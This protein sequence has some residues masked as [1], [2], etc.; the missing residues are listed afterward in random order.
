M[1]DSV[2]PPRA[3]SRTRTAALRSDLAL[4]NLRFRSKMALAVALPVCA[5]LAVTLVGVTSRAGVVTTETRVGHL[6]GP[7]SALADVTS[8]LDD[9]A[10]LS[11]WTLAS[12]AAPA[13][14]LA[15]ARLATDRAIA[16]VRRELPQLRAAH[17]DAAVTRAG[18]LFD[19]FDLLGEQRRFI[20]LG[21]MPID[22]ATGYYDDTVTIV[23]GLLDSMNGTVHDATEVANLRDFTTVVRFLAAAGQ[24]HSVLT[25]GFAQ[26]ALSTGQTNDL[27]GAIASQDAYQALFLSQAGPS[28]RAAFERGYQPDGS[29]VNR[30]HA[31]R[32]VALAG[33]IGKGTVAV[34]DWYNATTALQTSLR[35]SAHNVLQAVERSGRD[36]KRAAERAMLFYGLGAGAALLAAIGLAY[37]I[38]RSTTRPLRQLTAAARD[39]SERQLP[40]L[41]QALHADPDDADFG[42]MHPI[43]TT[44]RD[45]VGE[46][47][48]AFNAIE[49]ATVDVAREHAVL[50]RQGI[51]DLYVNLARRN[52]S[53][54]ER[55]LRAIDELESRE[56][57]P[58]TLADLFRVDH[59]AT[60]MRRNAE[61]LLIL[62]G[63]EPP[64]PSATSVR[65]F[66]VVRAAA[67]EIDD[68]A[69]IDL[70]E[71][72]ETT[73]IAG[74][75]MIDLTHLLAELLEN[76]TAFSPPDS[77]VV[78]RAVAVESGYEIAV[79]DRGL[80][81][82]SDALA[83]ANQ[84][85][86]EPAPPRL[87]LSRSLGHLVVARLAARAGVHVELRDGAPGVVA[88]VSIPAALLV[89]PE[90]A[91]GT[92]G[93][94]A[95][96]LPRRV[97]RGV[98][99][100]ARI[101]A[102][103]S[104]NGDGSPS[105][106]EAGDAEVRSAPTGWT[107][108]GLPRRIRKSAVKAFRRRTASQ[109][110]S[111][112]EVFEIVARYESGRRRGLRD[113]ASGAA[114][115]GDP[116]PPREPASDD[117]SGGARPGEQ[118]RDRVQPDALPH[119]RPGQTIVPERTEPAPRPDARSPEETFELV[120]R[121]E[122]GRRRAR[123]NG[124]TEGADNG[125]G[126]REPE[127]PGHVTRAEDG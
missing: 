32:S 112:D 21:V 64:R 53:L 45:E 44:S 69:R 99:A 59:F 71:V 73:A 93:S 88:V 19:Q 120:A 77:R 123:I 75:V 13:D 35:A 33:T 26:R 72:D 42:T 57:D 39:V 70:T 106:D 103:E 76:A 82:Q 111:P 91:T 25:A 54:I 3:R 117:A 61:S 121:Y 29:V 7:A 36:R 10:R 15:A 108:S 52:Q 50:L 31:M 95:T 85:L 116:V 23:V 101:E 63:V 12:P 110:R 62:A 118:I 84:L 80:G 83:A 1:T 115:V 122:W 125:E 58:D 98:E 66:D 4:R 87:E 34:G 30:V 86:R 9:E 27:L 124:G 67:S 41:L 56:S 113:A 5:L 6:Y 37:A 18:T 14:R 17:A 22:A 89:A 46:L 24:E 127:Q 48:H 40:Q 47:A 79:A 74:R 126:V 68:Y 51:S 119:R 104:A 105:S 11:N 81:M 107:P 90:P 2:L 94:E 78:V 20:D 60:R 100:R 49:T 28:L 102:A 92:A 43:E 65:I 55:Q 8:A 16:A 109:P 97:T 96:A 114:S 38:V